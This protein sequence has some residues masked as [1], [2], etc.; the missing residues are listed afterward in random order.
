MPRHSGEND[1]DLHN[2]GRS[3]RIGPVA[4]GSHVMRSETMS[5][6]GESG[7]A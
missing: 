5:G 1:R 4:D 2:V 6:V 7:R 3:E